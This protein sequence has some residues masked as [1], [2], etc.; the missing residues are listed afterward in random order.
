MTL[1]GWVFWITASYICGIYLA[2]C[3]HPAFGTAVAAAGLAA[4][5]FGKRTAGRLLLASG[6]FLLAYEP[7]VAGAG[8]GLQA[9]GRSG[10]FEGVAE[11]VTREGAILSCDGVRIWLNGKSIHLD[12]M[13]GDSLRVLGLESWGSLAVCAHTVIP[14]SG[15]FARLRRTAVLTWRERLGEGPTSALVAALLSGERSGISDT[16]RD[17]FRE[18]GTIHILSVSGYHVAIAGSLVY[19]LMGAAARRRPLLAAF[20]CSLTTGAYTQF[21]GARPPAVR[22]TV[23]ATAAVF[24]SALG[25]RSPGTAVWSLA[26][27]VVLATYPGAAFDA[28]AQMSFIAVLILIVYRWRMG[29]GWTRPL[30]ALLAGVSITIGLAPVLVP[31]YGGLATASAPATVVTTPLMAFTMLTG[32]LTLLPGVWHPAARLTEWAVFLWLWILE[33]AKLPVVYFEG[34]FWIWPWLAAMIL[35]W[36]VSERRTFLRRFR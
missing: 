8:S 20:L 13:E 6:F 9:P 3:L 35:M 26:A 1:S 30:Q 12:T 4:A 25:V 15:L 19:L 32:A 27:A 7:K 36:L 34:S 17:L 24:L 21:S 16:V 11:R 28:G 29:G 14:G 18:T 10:V 2:P 23:M 31:L 22:A 33:F 5:A